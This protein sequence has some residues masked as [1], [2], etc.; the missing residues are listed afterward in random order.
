MYK[1]HFQSVTEPYSDRTMDLIGD[2]LDDLD[3]F[4]GFRD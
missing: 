2:D 4:F 3:K 1:I